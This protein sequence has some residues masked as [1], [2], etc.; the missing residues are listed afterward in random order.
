MKKALVLTV[1]T[2]LASSGFALAQ[3]RVLIEVPQA[4]RDYVIANPSDPVVIEGEISDGYV[5]P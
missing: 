2:F 3:D 4:A 1:A 5:L